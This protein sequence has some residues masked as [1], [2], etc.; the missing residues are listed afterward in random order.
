MAL[1]E[2]VRNGSVESVQ[3]ILNEVEDWGDAAGACGVDL[4][5]K[6]ENGRTALHIAAEKNM[7]D[8]VGLLLESGA[9][10]NPL[11]KAMKTPLYLAAEKNHSDVMQVLI[12]G[13]FDPMASSQ[14]HTF[15]L[16]TERNDTAVMEELLVNLVDVDERGC[17]LGDKGESGTALQVAARNGHVYALEMLLWHGANIDA[18]TTPGGLTALYAAAQADH[19]HAL[20]LLLK[21]GADVNKLSTAGQDALMMAVCNDNV[22]ATKQ[23]LQHGASTAHADY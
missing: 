6:D 1:F 15:H 21:A 13:D 22:C 10:A 9:S 8:I 5:D 4:E 14:V 12:C 7:S 3:D 17:A 11:D 23:L 2:A 19:T 16:A 18:A 20:T